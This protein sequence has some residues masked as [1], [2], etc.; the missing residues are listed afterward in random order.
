[1]SVTNWK[2]PTTVDTE[3][4]PAGSDWT[5]PGNAVSSNDQDATNAVSKNKSTYYLRTYNFGFTTADVPEGATIDGIE[6]DIECAASVADRIM[7]SE[8]WLRDAS[9]RIGTSQHLAGYWPTGDAYRTHGGATNKWGTSIG[10]AAIRA[11]T[12]GADLVALCDGNAADAYVDHIRIRVYWTAGAT[13]LTVASASHILTSPQVPLTVHLTVN[14]A[15]HVLA[16]PQAPLT[17]PL[18]INGAAHD[19]V[20]GSPTLQVVIP[21]A[22]TSHVHAPGSPTLRVVIPPASASHVHTAESPDLEESGAIDLIVQGAAHTLAS[23]TAG[24]VIPLLVNPTSH[25]QAAGTVALTIP[26][27]VAG[28]AHTHAAEVPYLVVPLLVNGAA[29]GHLAGSPTLQVVLVAAGASHV[30]TSEAPTL[31]ITF[32]VAGASHAHTAESPTLEQEGVTNLIVQGASHGHTAGSVALVVFLAVNGAGHDHL[33]GSPTLTIFLV[34][35]AAFHTLAS[36]SPD[37][38]QT[39]ILGAQDATHVH[40]AD[41]INLGGAFTV[42]SST[43]AL[44]DTA[45]PPWIVAP[46]EVPDLT[47]QVSERITTVQVKNF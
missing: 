13:N 6:V 33:A 1:M 30:L 9:G 28:A 41:N 20:S 46:A 44:T 8:C 27:V 26:L 12:F 14:G 31:G 47:V 38:E 10:D 36:G 29:H 39:R 37:L 19:H 42:Q 40:Q 22:S 2:S 4:Y 15:A 25:I 17:I 3:S 43:H 21:P 11:S 34:P 35:A 32:T 23:D 45:Q 24:L 5:N 16:S 7:D 18:L